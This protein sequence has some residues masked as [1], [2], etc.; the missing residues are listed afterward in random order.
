MGC[1]SIR[2][3]NINLKYF[4]H[5]LE[6]IIECCSKTQFPK[7]WGIILIH[8]FFTRHFQ[9]LCHRIADDSLTANKS[10]DSFSDQK[11]ILRIYCTRSVAN[12]D[13]QIKLRLPRKGCKFQIPRRIVTVGI[14]DHTA[15]TKKSMAASEKRRNWILVPWSI[16][17]LLREFL[18]YC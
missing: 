8:I 3:T 17:G 16:S 11:E 12:G 18:S 9:A 1:I 6:C 10:S 5:T 14:V 13:L 15:H 7:R 2:I 4:I